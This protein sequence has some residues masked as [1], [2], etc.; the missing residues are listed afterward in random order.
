MDFQARGFHPTWIAV[1]VTGALIVAFVLAATT[2]EV[3]DEVR[4]SM[5]SHVASAGDR[6]E[7]QSTRFPDDSRSLRR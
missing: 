5:P 4:A 7:T 2:V 3:S 6:I 1:P